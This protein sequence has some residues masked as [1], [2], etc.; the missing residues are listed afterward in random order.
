M[1]RFVDP[2]HLGAPLGLALLATQL[3][4]GCADTSTQDLCAQY[5]GLVSAAEKLRAEDPA[6][7]QA[8]ELRAAADDVRNELDQF[9]AVAEGRLD[10]ALTRLRDDIDAV[11]QAAV[12]A[13]EDARKTAEPMVQ[14]ALDRVGEAWSIVQDLAETQ[15]PPQ[16]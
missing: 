4:G 6:T 10:D 13:G 3:L 9:Q 14:D 5:D 1:T 16:Q 12:D 15:C 7:A 11:R 2:R 8:D